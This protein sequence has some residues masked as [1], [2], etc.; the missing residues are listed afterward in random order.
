MTIIE[1]KKYANAA[2]E[3]RKDVVF[4]SWHNITA[5]TDGGIGRATSNFSE[6]PNSDE[7]GRRS[8]L[9]GL[10]GVPFDGLR[11]TVE[12]GR[13]QHLRMPLR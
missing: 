2:K 1:A 9:S 8:A 3:Y 11:L 7:L 12:G 6:K 5:T 10:R 4:R 13:L